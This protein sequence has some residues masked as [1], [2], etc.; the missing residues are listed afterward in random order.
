MG[1]PLP[2]A[3]VMVV[4]D[5]QELRMLGNSVSLPSSAERGELCVALLKQS[6][7]SQIRGGCMNLEGTFRLECMLAVVFWLLII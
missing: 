1:G 5:L 3:A 2:I 6:A 4:T 7:S